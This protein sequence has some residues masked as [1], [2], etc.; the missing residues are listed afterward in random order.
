MNEQQIKKAGFIQIGK[1]SGYKISSQKSADKIVLAPGS[2]AAEGKSY[3]EY[4]DLEGAILLIP[5]ESATQ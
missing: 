4:R 2:G 1:K 5:V 3:R